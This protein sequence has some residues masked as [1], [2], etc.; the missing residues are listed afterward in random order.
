MEDQTQNQPEEQEIPN[1]AQFQVQRSDVNA[2]EGEQNDESTDPESEN[3]GQP[4][5]TADSEYTPDEVEYADGEGTTL[6]QA[7]DAE[8]EDGTSDT[9]T[10]DDRGL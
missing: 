5:G 7:I 6:N 2:A 8:E 9:E 4:S 10:D 1:V 3:D